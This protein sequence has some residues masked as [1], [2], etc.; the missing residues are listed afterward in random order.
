MSSNLKKIIFSKLDNNIIIEESE[1]YD[2]MNETN[3]NND[4]T[5][6]NIGESQK[7]NQINKINT[8][9]SEFDI[10]FGSSDHFDVE[11]AKKMEEYNKLPEVVKIFKIIQQKENILIRPD[12]IGISNL[13][14]LN[15][16]NDELINE[17]FKNIDLDYKFCYHDVI[18][19]DKKNVKSE[20]NTN[21]LSKVVKLASK[22]GT[23]K[24][25][26]TNDTSVS[27]P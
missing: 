13:N 27:I 12:A 3:F 15:S 1:M 21:I 11:K 20:L 26:K 22:T 18:S 6:K 16:I 2:Y 14:N 23:K 25:I 24:S 10:A 4:N 7:N 17:R 8:S 19:I 5:S 9:D